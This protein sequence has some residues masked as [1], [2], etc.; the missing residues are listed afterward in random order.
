MFG[1]QNYLS[2]SC[3]AVVG[4]R[5]K[6]V[7]FVTMANAST[8][9]TPVFDMSTFPCSSQSAMARSSPF[10][11]NP[12][13]NTCHGCSST[14]L[15]ADEEERHS[16]SQDDMESLLPNSGDGGYS[17]AM[18]LFQKKS[19]NRVTVKRMLGLGRCNR[20][21]GFGSLD[22]LEQLSLQQRFHHLFQGKVPALRT[23]RSKRRRKNLSSCGEYMDN[24][25]E[26]YD[27]SC[28]DGT[29]EYLDS[30]SSYD[31]AD[32]DNI[33]SAMEAPAQFSVPKRNEVL[34]RCDG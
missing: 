17:K 24:T 14:F 20:I 15:L 5:G 30:S 18:R 12:T 16:C 22:E 4:D 27:D 26:E 2:R 33:V 8:M 13:D 28:G 34:K 7:G 29:H 11:T 32:H 25:N 21:R 6:P 9:A 23:I 31:S 3:S 10:T 1:K 19:W